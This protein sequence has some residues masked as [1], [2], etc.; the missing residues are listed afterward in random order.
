[1]PAGELPPEFVFLA[2]PVGTVSVVFIALALFLLVV[3]WARRRA[4]DD[5]WL[6]VGAATYTSVLVIG[7]SALAVALHWWQG[8]FF[9]SLPV[10]VLA[11]IYVPFSIAGYTLWLGL[12]R[13]LDRKTRRP[14][15]IYALVVLAFIPVVLVVD[16]IQMSRGQFSMGGGYTVWADALAGQVV[17]WSPV[18]FYKLLQRGASAR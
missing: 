15:L 6:A 3:I 17:M 14:L 16:P 11:A 5:R 1:M 12:Y 4:H 8:S 9:T 7:I 18:L 13:W 10:P 2:S